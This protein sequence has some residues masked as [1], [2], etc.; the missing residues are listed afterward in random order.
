VEKSSTVRLQEQQFY[1]SFY[2]NKDIYNV[3]TPS[4]CALL[5]IVL[6][7][8]GPEAI[9]ESFCNCMKAQ[10][11]SDGQSNENLTRRTRLSWCLHP[12]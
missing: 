2:S 11:Q 12:H 4:S 9:A 1:R 6:A 7:K 8:G 10:Q 5:D 3:A